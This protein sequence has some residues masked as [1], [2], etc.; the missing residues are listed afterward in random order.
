MF[1]LKKQWTI[2]RR[3]IW[4]SHG[5][6]GVVIDVCY[7]NFLQVCMNLNKFLSVL[8]QGWRK[9]GAGATVLNPILWRI[10]NKPFSIKDVSINLPFADHPPSDFQTFRDLLCSRSA[11]ISLVCYSAFCDC[12]GQILSVECLPEKKSF[13]AQTNLHAFMK[14]NSL[15]DSC[16]VFILY[17]SK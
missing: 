8:V 7:Q 13:H 16:L 14:I 11:R 9:Q 4:N 2:W 15:C 6:L 12:L 1:S 17:N 3:S 5:N 10:T